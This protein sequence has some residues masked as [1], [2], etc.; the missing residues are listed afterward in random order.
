MMIIMIYQQ[1]FQVKDRFILSGRIG[2][3]TGPAI[4]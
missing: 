2:L 4:S 3:K 1:I